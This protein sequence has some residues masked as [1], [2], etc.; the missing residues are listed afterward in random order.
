MPFLPC[1]H[2]WQSADEKDEDEE[3]PHSFLSLWAALNSCGSRDNRLEGR[4]VRT[5]KMSGGEEEVLAC[6]PVSEIS[7]GKM[8]IIK[9]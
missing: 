1:L 3:Q 6:H 4:P 7:G 2:L 8:F 9:A 5:R